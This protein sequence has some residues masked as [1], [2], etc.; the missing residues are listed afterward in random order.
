MPRKGILADGARSTVE[1]V[2]NVDVRVRL[3]QDGVG[4]HTGGKLIVDHAAGTVLQVQSFDG[5]AAGGLV[6]G[7]DGIFPEDG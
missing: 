2:K 6:V 4:P 3:Y 7:D 1:H 5:K